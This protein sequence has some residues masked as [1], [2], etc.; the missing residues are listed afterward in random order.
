MFSFLRRGVTVQDTLNWG[1]SFW[2]LCLES[3]VWCL[4]FI[5]G[6]WLEL[7]IV[8]SF[9]CWLLHLSWCDAGAE[10]WNNL[11]VTLSL[12]LLCV[13]TSGAWLQLSQVDNSA[14]TVSWDVFKYQRKMQVTRILTESHPCDALKAGAWLL[15]Y[16]LS[17]YSTYLG[18]SN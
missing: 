5:H 18:T 8:N 15:L 16:F 14:D 13:S 7:F 12:T 6:C 4:V 10:D 1:V 3:L 11:I 2:S 9:L 17:F